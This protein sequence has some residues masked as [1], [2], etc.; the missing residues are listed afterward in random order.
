MAY[1]VALFDGQRGD[2]ASNLPDL[3]GVLGG[4]GRRN[5]RRVVGD[6]RFERAD[7]GAGLA[8]VNVDRG[9]LGDR[10]Q[11]RTQV[12][13]WIETTCGPPR[14]QE[15]LLGRL[16]AEPSVC[17]DPVRHGVHKARVGS[18]HRVDCVLVTVSKPL[19][20][21]RV[22][23]RHAARR[24]RPCASRGDCNDGSRPV[25]GAPEPP[26]I[27]AFVRTVCGYLNI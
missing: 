16:L 19:P 1:D 4:H 11:P 10:G 23:R 26:P 25:W 13:V 9:P 8:A 27:P 12:S 18:I 2:R 6:D 7:G 14:L 17:E 5:Q 21:T 15:S 20:D 3:V 22:N 24:R